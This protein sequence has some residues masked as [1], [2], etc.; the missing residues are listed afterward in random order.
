MG[1]LAGLGDG[2][3]HQRRDVGAVLVGRQPPVLVGI[4]FGLAEDLAVRR[5]A[6][7]RAGAELPVE[8]DKL[9]DV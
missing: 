7:A 8:G 9:E 4:P 6:Q 5:D 3:A 1:E 2:G